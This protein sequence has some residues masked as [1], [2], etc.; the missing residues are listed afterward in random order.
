MVKNIPPKNRA[1]M[2]DFKLLFKKHPVPMWIYDLES[3]AILDVNDAAVKKYGYTRREFLGL[4]IKDIRPEEEIP[5]LLEDVKKRR[6]PWQFSGG[7]KHQLKNGKII[8]VEIT[9]HTLEFNERQAALVMIQ[10]VTERQEMQRALQKSE[11]RYRDLVENSQILMCTHDLEGNILS[12]NDYAVKLTGYPRKAL[13]KMN[14][15][16]TLLPER[17]NKFEAYIKRIQAKGR[18][19]GEMTVKTAKGE[20]RIWEYD[21]S[22]RMDGV[23]QPI[24]RGMARDITE[25]KK[26][27]KALHASEKRFRALIK[28]GLDNISLLAMDGTLLWESPSSIST[29]GYVQDEHIGRDI[30]ELMHPDDRAWT[31]GLFTQVAQTPGESRQ[32][33]FRLKHRNGEWRWVD[34]IA[35][36][37]LNEPAVEAIVIN[38]RD[39]TERKQTQ[40][41]MFL[42]T[43]ALNAASNAVVIQDKRGLIEWVNPAFCRLTGYSETEVTGKTLRELVRSG[44]HDESF[45][46]ELWDTVLSGKVWRGEVINRRKDGSTY[47]EEQVITPLKSPEGVVTHVVAVKEDVSERKQAEAIL[48]Q[49]EEKFRTLFENVPVGLYRTSADGQLLEVN[50]ALVKMFGCANKEDLL[51]VTAKDLYANPTGENDFVRAVENGETFFSTET[52]FRRMDGSTFCGRDHVQIVRDENGALRFCEGSIID[53]TERKNMEDALRQ[54]EKLF[55]NAFQNSAIGMALV[56]PDGRVLNANSRL[57]SLLGYSEMEILTKTF[58]DITHPDDLEA[59]ERHV[60][61]LLD[62]KHETYTMEK[63]YIHKNGGVVWALLAVSLVRDDTGVPLFFISQVEDITERKIVGDMLRESE[64]RYRSLFEDSPIALWEEDF[65]QVKKRLDVLKEQGVTDLRAYFKAHPE[66]LL[67]C[68]SLIRVLDVNTAAMKMFKAK[69]KDA[70]FGTL[71][72]PSP[73]EFENNPEDFI[74]I[75]EG[76]TSNSWEGSDKTLDDEPLQITLSWSVVPGHEADYSKVIVSTMDIT[77]RKHAQDKLEQSEERFSKAFQASPTAQ[78]ISTIEDGILVDVNKSFLRLFEYERDEVIG[79]KSL[80]MDFYA[81]SD[82]RGE[83]NRLLYEKGEVKNR[84]LTGVTKT[85]KIRHTVYSAEVIVIN[86]REHILAT[87]MDVTEQKQANDARDESERRYRSLFEDSPISLWEEDYSGV[88]QKLDGLKQAGVTDFEAYFSEHPEAVQE[89]VSLVKILNVNKASVELYGAKSKPE[90]T[91]SMQKLLRTD[92]LVRSFQKELLNIA[93][94][95]TYFE[96]EEA[97]NTLGG[98]NLYVSIV[99][100]V[101]PGYEETLSRVIVSIVDLTQRKKA[102]EQ[103]RLQSTMLEVSANAIIIT[104]HNGMIEWANPAFSTLTGYRVPDEVVGKNPRQLLKSGRQDRK[105]YKDLWDT[106]LDGKVWQGELVNRR[107]DGTL[108]NEEM[109]IAPYSNDLG[110]ITHLIAVKQDITER[111]QAEEERKR[112]IY[113]L[114]ERV[115]EL[116]FLH[117]SSRIFMDNSRT[118]E[119]VLQD[120][121]D[122]IPAAWQYPE[123]TSAR[124]G[125]NGYQYVTSNFKETDWMQIQF[126]DLPNGELGFIQVAYLEEKPKQYEG[127]FLKEERYLLESLAEKLQTY[128]RS[129]MADRAIKLHNRELSLLVEAGRELSNTLE[130]REV[131]EIAYN[132][133]VQHV[134]VDQFQVYTYDADSQMLHSEFA[135][136]AKGETDTSAPP[137]LRFEPQRRDVIDTVIRTGKS[138]IMADYAESRSSPEFEYD[139]ETRKS[140]I[141]VPI[142]SQGQV[143]GILKISHHN[144]NVYNE[145]HLHF[146]ESLAFRVSASISNARLFNELQGELIQRRLVEDEMRQLNAELED[147]VRERTEQSE[148]AKRRLELATHAGQIGVWEYIPRQNRA[149]W[150]ERMY[151]IH[152]ARPDDFDGTAEGWAKFF[153]P[154]DIKRAKVNTQLAVTHNLLMN[155]EHRIV[156]PDGS[157]RHI[158]TNAVTVFAEDGTPDRIVG[159]SVDITERRQIE[160]SL[161]ESEAYARLL[162]DAAPDSVFVSDANGTMLDVN[163]SFEKLHKIRR[164]DLNGR[165][166][167]ELGIFPPEELIKIKQHIKDVLGGRK[168]RPIE[169]KFHKNRNELHTLETHSYAIEVSGRRLILSTSRDITAH[170]KLEQAL[171]LANA[172]MEDALR[173]KDEF[174]ANMSHELRT[175]LNAILGI[176]ESLEEQIVGNLNDKQL[177][178]IQIVKE[179]GRHLLELINDILDISKIEAGRMELDIR[180]LSVEKLCQSSLR[181][182]KELAQKKSINVSFSVRGNVKVV[183][184]DER[185]LRQSLVNLLINA[186]KFTEEGKQIGLEVA[187][188]PARNEIT[189]TVWDTGIGIA[190][191]D[192]KYLFK[193]FT[194]L[195]AGLAREFQGTGLGLALVAQMVR[196]HGGRV[197]AESELGKGSRFTIAL[198]WQ[199]AEQAAQPKGTGELPPHTHETKGERKGRVLIVEDTDVI[200][201]LLKDY[202]EVRGYH[203][204]VARNGREGIETAKQQRPDIILMDVMMP[205]MDGIEATK[206][207]RKEESLQAVPII[208]LTALAMP[209]DRERCLAAGMTDYMS[210]PVRMDELE[211]KLQQHLSMEKTDAK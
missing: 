27:E 202:L 73:G 122:A 211:Q 152:H 183:R 157:I 94:G 132:Y 101:V 180:P 204:F 194:Q 40:E 5:R 154:E 81:A 105:F 189:F 193:P 10:D 60:Q 28:N 147:R 57:C 201:S 139:K 12:V 141:F 158:A 120:V 79:K 172:E 103:L 108:Y 123:I 146:M 74:A 166:I 140:A 71:A 165:N 47:I 192:L 144:L 110:E 205:I 121:V 161:R 14:I 41:Q 116:T 88:K 1:K 93:N 37:M 167:S 196:L 186:V 76:R 113:D 128:L 62:G 96:R 49:S 109:T 66:E 206:Y 61:E 54:S 210:K 51:K 4:T 64:H 171:K 102:E 181:M 130:L 84:E 151:I 7:W 25:Q 208:A 21:N 117:N 95:V 16:D 112:L 177:K 115:K 209:G 188:S 82:Q 197:S 118:E 44:Q 133:T 72:E 187:G 127:P 203:V 56:A 53:I 163:K 46:Q 83:I 34:A 182:I 114:G 138:Q 23:E 35:T 31:R 33:E 173:V 159:I 32:G 36:N 174:L 150:D 42:Q 179:S 98:E 106:I 200:V 85:G 29:L 19:R 90:L 59:D 24:V 191:E 169:L 207:I 58:R 198:P 135:R 75:A 26:V 9:S 185:R 148:A 175:P 119:Q 18:V 17:R 43:T 129:L 48:A 190:K 45:Y 38:Y 125:Y 65:S 11:D 136:T 2:G 162:F 78:T 142:L 99:W 134:P 77:E 170:K 91:S 30:F 6:P 92:D 39:V 55:K 126:F 80:E 68:E 104:D 69:N 15:K 143:S 97:D 137:T 149:I 124:L 195:N 153:H 20:T 160:Q 13:L 155:N 67:E 131:L 86:E 145:E 52:E 156:W 70:L 63:R 111:K 164:D 178:Y 87:I 199:A 50:P 100:S 22:L 176:S 89:C 184:G 3:L 8:E 107:K 168:S